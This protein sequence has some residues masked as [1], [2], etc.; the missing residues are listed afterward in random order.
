M[1]R[2]IGE[3][4][5][6]FDCLFCCQKKFVSGT[7]EFRKNPSEQ[8]RVTYKQRRIQ[9]QIQM[10]LLRCA[11]AVPR[12]SNPVEGEEERNSSPSPTKR[13]RGNYLRAIK[14]DRNIM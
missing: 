2:V 13:K 7:D 4:L 10:G 6:G 9:K 14:K 3:N 12:Q 5:H 8:A 1:D 11:V